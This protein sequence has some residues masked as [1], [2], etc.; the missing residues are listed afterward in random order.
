M[1]VDNL[2]TQ[3]ENHYR[4][5]VRSLTDTTLLNQKIAESGL[6]QVYIAN[7]LGITTR[8]W[9]N[10]R[11]GRYPFKVEEIQALCELLNITSLREKE[12]IFFANM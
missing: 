5:G 4:K 2:T 1:C 6:K 3:S 11:K 7:H 12:R 10:K 8:T 9:Q